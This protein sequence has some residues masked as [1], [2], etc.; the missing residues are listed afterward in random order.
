[1]QAEGAELGRYLGRLGELVAGLEG[2]VGQLEQST[3]QAS[4]QNCLTLMI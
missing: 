2:R 4:K 3:H 1:M